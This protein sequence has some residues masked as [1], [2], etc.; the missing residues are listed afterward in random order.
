M[1]ALRCYMEEDGY[2]SAPSLHKNH[3]DV[4]VLEL[5]EE[6]LAQ[7]RQQGD[8][9]HPLCMQPAMETLR[10][11]YMEDT[12]PP[13]PFVSGDCLNVSQELSRAAKHRR[14][15]ERLQQMQDSVDVPGRQRPGCARKRRLE[16]QASPEDAMEDFRPKDTGDKKQFENGLLVPSPHR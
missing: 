14:I 9:L 3:V 7:M 10:A 6:E 5:I 1:E 4:K 13:A 16:D 8:D 15:D 11:C 12:T 2:V